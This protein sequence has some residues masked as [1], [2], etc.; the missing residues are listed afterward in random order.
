VILAWA[1]DEE[2]GGGGLRWLL[3]HAPDSVAAEIAINEGGEIRLGGGGGIGHGEPR[4]RAARGELPGAEKSDPD[5]APL[6]RGETGHASVP[7]PDNAIYRLA[8]ALDRLARHRF[9]ARI[10]PV[11]RAYLLA[12]APLEPPALGAA[13]RAVANAKGAPPAQAL[14]VLDADPVLAATLRTTCVATLLSAGTPVTAPPAE[15][16]STL[17]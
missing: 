3:E 13:M 6:A 9:P 8:A 16:R 1:G 5:Y 11:T 17:P 10:L 2:S 4:E 7:L 12:R 14:A 15:A